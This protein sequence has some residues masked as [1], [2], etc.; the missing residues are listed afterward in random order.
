MKNLKIA[1]IPGDGIGNEVVPVAIKVL[2][3]IANIHGGI[4]FGF[5]HFPYGCE[6][7]LKNGAMM[8]A[9]G[10]ERLK[11]FDAIFLG[12]VGNAKLV[13]DHVSLWGLLIKIRREFEQVINIRPAKVLKGVKS[14]LIN[15]KDFDL[16]VVRE[17]SE[18]EYSSVGGR[19]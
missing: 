18:G 6:Y 3:T 13:P 14:P 15:P 5:T 8:A 10:L 16:M 7:Y 11:E 17:N 9:D 1:S 2:D 4:K 19:I 12:A